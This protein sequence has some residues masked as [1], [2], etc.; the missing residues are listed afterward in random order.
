MASRASSAAGSDYRFERKFYVEDLSTREIEAL[1]FAHPAMFSPIHARRF[2]NNVYFDA[3]DRRALVE[4]VDGVADRCK[5]RIRWYGD[6]IGEHRAAL[7]FKIKR[8]QV[9]RKATFDAGRIAV[10][11]GLSRRALARALRAVAVPPAFAELVIASEPTL[12]NRYRRRYYLS[13][14]GRY[15]LTLD[16]EQ[17]FFPF[18]AG[19]A[20]LLHRSRDRRG[21]VVELKYAPE[22]DGGAAAVTNV[23][24]FRLTKSSKYVTGLLRLSW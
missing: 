19:A 17:E 22:H 21:S 23:F 6:L 8:G 12:V 7:E 11:P 14:D 4:N 9:G 3:P 5:V 13:A 18:V 24:P 16:D 15:R 2:V 20:T 1:V 10:S